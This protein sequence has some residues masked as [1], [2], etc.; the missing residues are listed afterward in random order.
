MMYMIFIH[1]TRFS[2]GTLFRK[3]YPVIYLF[4][5]SLLAEQRK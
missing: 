3:M 4:D 1:K 5:K 2:C